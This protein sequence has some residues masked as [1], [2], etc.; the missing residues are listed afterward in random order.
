MSL[1][2]EKNKDL[3]NL[4]TLKIPVKTKYFTIV[5][6]KDDLKEALLFARNKKLD[7][8]ILGGG[9]NTF[10]KHDFKGLVI[11]NEIRGWYIKK[12]YKNKVVVEAF[13]GEPW[14]KFVYQMASLNF[15]GVENLAS[16]YGTVGAA[17]VQN[18]GAYG[19][20]LKD[21]FE[22]LLAID[23]KTGKEK[24]FFKEDCQF[25]YRDSFF[26]KEKNKFKYF[27]LSVTISLK[28][29]GKVKTNY[30]SI[31]KVLEEKGIKDP[32]PVDMLNV[33]NE[34]RTKKLPSPAILPNVGSFFKNPEVS[35]A[36]FLEIQKK[37]KDVPYF[38][39]EKKAFKIPAAWLIEKTG[40]KGKEFSS[41]SMYEK[42]ALILVNHGEAKAK[43]VIK[44][45]N[46]VKNKVKNMFG[47]DLEEEVNII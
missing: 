22:S 8:F 47:L 21:V 30:G 6:D 39:G 12:E 38:K 24:V 2:I 27:I 10:F 28:K 19:V 29:E 40:L 32:K 41:V 31:S 33:I 34:I 35:K 18:I 9:S 4:L 5:K 11:K 46:K 45:S 7:V 26:K 43:D 1:N 14:P 20:E 36:R 3:T 23:I 15:Y 16:I 42:Q 44:L 17:P 13:S 37:Y 25:G